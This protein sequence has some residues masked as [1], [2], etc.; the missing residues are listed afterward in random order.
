MQTLGARGTWHVNGTKIR[1]SDSTKFRYCP[2][3]SY[4]IMKFNLATEMA[5]EIDF[6]NGDFRKFKGTATSTLTLDDLE[7]HIVRFVSSTSIHITIVHMVLLS[8]IV[9]G[10]MD[11]QTSFHQCQQV[12]FAKSKDDLIIVELC[13]IFPEKMTKKRISQS[14]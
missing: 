1:K 12:I 11:G 2:I 10:R 5:K 14:E 13:S 8:S 7:S 4:S 9:N 3:V 6:E